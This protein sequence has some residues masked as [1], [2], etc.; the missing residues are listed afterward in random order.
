MSILTI[1]KESF[2]TTATIRRPDAMNAVNFE[3]MDRLEALLDQLEKDDEI[4]LFVLTGSEGSFIS[5]G[6]LREFHQIKDAE[7]AKSMTLRML[8]LLNRIKNLPFWTLAALNGDAYGGGWEMMLSFDFRVARDDVNIGFTQGKFYLPPAW[9][10]ITNL[11]EVA[12]REQALYWLASNRVISSGEALTH[13]LIQDVFQ[14]DQF[15]KKLEELKKELIRNDR[16][17]IDY[18]KRKDPKSPSDE[19]DP[20]SHFWESDEHLKRVDR[21]LNRKK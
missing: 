20:F 21:F 14:S 9:G 1:H 5:G 8:Q 17:F 12:G 15:D 13:G 11:I 2:I 16:T 4:R 7:G 19:I 3:L 6:D 18:L 10:G